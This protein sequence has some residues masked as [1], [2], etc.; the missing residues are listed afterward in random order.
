[1]AQLA[2]RLRFDLTDAFTRDV[3]L[4]AD[5]FKRVVGIQ[6]D[7]RSAYAELSLPAG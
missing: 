1:M 7:S 3:E 4:F 6:V 2:Q 5:L